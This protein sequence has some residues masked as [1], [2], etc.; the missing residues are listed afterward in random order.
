MPEGIGKTFEKSIQNSFTVDQ[1]MERKDDE[2]I[3]LTKRLETADEVI[4]GLQAEVH[5]TVTKDEKI[6]DLEDL[7]SKRLHSIAR[8]QHEATGY[9]DE[10]NTLRDELDHSRKENSALRELAIVMLGK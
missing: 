2:I 3:K 9:R 1:A 10:I 7:A 5:L 6:K 4:R 8:L